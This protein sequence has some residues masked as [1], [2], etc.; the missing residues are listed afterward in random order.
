MCQVLLGHGGIV[1]SET[2]MISALRNTFQNPLLIWVTSVDDDL[3]HSFLLHTNFLL[4]AVFSLDLGDSAPLYCLGLACW[5]ACSQ[6]V[7][8][9]G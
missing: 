2:D 3:T 4:S 8:I 1:V 6:V 5:L 9:E 7:R